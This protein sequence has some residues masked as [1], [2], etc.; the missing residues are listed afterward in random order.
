MSIN[1][2]FEKETLLDSYT[3]NFSLPFHISLQGSKRKYDRDG[4]WN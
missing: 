3:P 4:H 1:K 2:K